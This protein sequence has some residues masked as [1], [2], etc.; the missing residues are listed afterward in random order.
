MAR[1]K[2]GSGK[3]GPGRVLPDGL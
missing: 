3:H 2:S 1:E